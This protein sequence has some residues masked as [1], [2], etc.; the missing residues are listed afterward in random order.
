MTLLEDV[1]SG[2]EDAFM[3]LFLQYRPIVF[4][5]QGIYF[6]K[7]FDGD[8]WLQE[9]L[10][11]FSESL[12]HYDENVGVT[13]GAYFKRNFENC[14][15]SHL[16]K[17]AAYKRKSQTD[18]VPFETSLAEEGYDVQFGLAQQVPAADDQLI[19]AEAVASLG[20]QLS[21]LEELAFTSY[22]LGQDCE[23]IAKRVEQSPRKIKLAYERARRKLIYHLKN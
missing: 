19:V 17:Q 18:A 7:D 15:K 23:D 8:D 21:S 11:A 22:I 14:I 6:V 16:R 10:I 1:R 2:D 5:L 12:N 20:G 3:E 13:F 9:G 4:K